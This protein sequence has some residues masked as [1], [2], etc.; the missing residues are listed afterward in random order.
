MGF[1]VQNVWR[2]LYINSNYKLCFSYFQKLLVF[3]WII[4]KELENVVFFCFWKWIFVVVYRYLCNG[5]VIVCC[6]QLE[7]SWWG[8]CNVDDE[9]LVMF[10]VKVC[11]LDLGIR[12]IG[13]FFSIGNNDISE[14]CDVDFDFFLIVC[15]GGESIVVF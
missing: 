10:I 2:V 6:S 13:G 8:W 9:Y 1:D 5:V 15:F 7:I 12:V 4:D 11:V 14:V 3:V